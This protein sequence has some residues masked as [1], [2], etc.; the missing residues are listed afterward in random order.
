MSNIRDY[1]ANLIKGVK[2]LDDKKIL[3]IEK[4]LFQKIINNNN[5]FDL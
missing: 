1:K 3:E 2:S 5:L 4:I